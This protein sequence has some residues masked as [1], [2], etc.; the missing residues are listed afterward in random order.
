[1]SFAA[2]WFMIRPIATSLPGICF[3]EKTTVGGHAR[4]R[5]ARFA[6]PARG[7]HHHLVAR[8]PHR[9]VEIDR[10]RE[11]LEITNRARDAEDAVERAARNA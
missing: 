8:Q 6:L 3:D 10:R 11:V 4:E 5:G 2:S 9:L 1:M 7:D